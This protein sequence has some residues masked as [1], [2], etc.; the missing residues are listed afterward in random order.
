MNQKQFDEFMEFGDSIR[1][2]LAD[3]ED[4]I[5]KR[6]KLEEWHKNL[7][8]WNQRVLESKWYYPF[9]N[10]NFVYFIKDNKGNR[11]KIGW[12]TCVH[13]RINTISK[14]VFAGNGIVIGLFHGGVDLES[15]FHEIFKEYRVVGESE[16]FFFSDEMRKYLNSVMTDEE[17]RLVMRLNEVYVQSEEK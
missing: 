11:V 13:N 14:Y 2:R 16:I 12:S 9:I 17:K 5:E 7:I 3:K 6:K 8:E 10:Q 1:S 4:Q 15:R